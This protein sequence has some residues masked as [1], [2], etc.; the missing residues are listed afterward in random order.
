M[1]QTRSGSRL[2]KKAIILLAAFLLCF[3]SI[4]FTAS[5]TAYAAS[6]YQF[7]T[8]DTGEKLVSNF[9]NNSDNDISGVFVI[10]VYDAAGKLVYVESQTFS[11]AK[12]GGFEAKQFSV[13]TGGYPDSYSFKAFCWDT[14]F[15]PLA[16]AVT[17][18]GALAEYVAAGTIIVASEADITYDS[19]LKGFCIAAGVTEFTFAD[20]IGGIGNAYSAVFNPIGGWTIM[21]DI[22]TIT[23]VRNTKTD[24]D[25]LRGSILPKITRS[26]LA[27]GMDLLIVTV[28]EGGASK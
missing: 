20:I 11:A 2:T 1:N 28:Y 16:P 25:N 23:I 7:D 8:W 13:R 4:V 14:Y 5:G 24:A 21:R 12:N 19:N 26:T 9:A 17:D 10:T 15:V 18:I 27:S 3:P 22:K 6:D